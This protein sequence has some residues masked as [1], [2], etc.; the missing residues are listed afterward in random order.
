MFYNWNMQYN[1]FSIYN[2]QLNYA[3]PD[4][5]H[6]EIITIEICSTRYFLF[7]IYNWNIQYQIFSIYNL[8]LK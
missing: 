3:V 6:L 2:L 5:F 4:T 7:T 1:I 8:Q